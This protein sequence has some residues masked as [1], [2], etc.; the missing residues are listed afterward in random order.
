M[1]YLLLLMTIVQ[2]KVFWNSFKT[3]FTTSEQDEDKI[4]SARVDLVQGNDIKLINSVLVIVI[5][6][7]ILFTASY[8]SMIAVYVESLPLAFVS[9]SLMVLNI[10]RLWNISECFAELDKHITVRKNIFQRLITAANL[11]YVMYFIY[12]LIIT[13]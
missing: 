5:L 7:A 10:K 3:I 2:A 11:L 8:Y 1:K 12:I 9:F 6:A 4:N 13:W